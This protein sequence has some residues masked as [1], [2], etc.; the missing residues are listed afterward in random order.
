[1][2]VKLGTWV[3]IEVGALV[4]DG[5]KDDVNEVAPFGPAVA[6]DVAEEVMEGAVVAREEAVSVK[7]GIEIMVGVDEGVA[8]EERTVEAENDTEATV[9]SDVVGARVTVDDGE[10]TTVIE[11]V[12]AGPETRIMRTL[13][14]EPSKTSRSW[15]W[16][17][18]S[19][20]IRYP[21]VS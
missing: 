8:E 10:E 13:L 15:L 9:V 7:V 11:V 14:A 1:V 19:K 3:W 4:M 5:T 21:L 20:E 2:L 12:V 17:P 16:A 18:L 6:T